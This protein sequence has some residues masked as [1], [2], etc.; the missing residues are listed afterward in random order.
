MRTYLKI[1][2]QVVLFLTSFNNKAVGPLNG[3]AIKSIGN[4]ELVNVLSH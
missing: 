3:N 4:N 2:T 1:T